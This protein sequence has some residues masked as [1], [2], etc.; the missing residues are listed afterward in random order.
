MSSEN[1]TV[2]PVEMLAAVPYFAGLDP[3]TLETVAQAA[4][5]RD[6]DPGQIIFLEGEA[7]T[8]LYVVQIGWLKAVKL[9]STGREQILRFMRPGDT[10]SEISVLAVMA[11]WFPAQ[12]AAQTSVRESL[13]YI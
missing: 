8:G 7:C 4:T 12:K 10:F 13:A 2:G 5:Q 6:Y 9:S 1:A 3:S 11:S